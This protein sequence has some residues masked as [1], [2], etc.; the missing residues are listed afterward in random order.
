MD[1]TSPLDEQAEPGPKR[2]V[3]A[4]AF[5]LFPKLPERVARATKPGGG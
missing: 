4:L 1:R 2:P 5:R 3:D